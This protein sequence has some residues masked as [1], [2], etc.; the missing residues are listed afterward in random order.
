MAAQR[1]AEHGEIIF[2][3][4]RIEHLIQQGGQKITLQYFSYNVKIIIITIPQQDLITVESYTQKVNENIKKQATVSQLA[5]DD[6]NISYL[7]PA[8]VAELMFEKKAFT[9]EFYVTLLY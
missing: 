5:G 1:A 8:A 2:S 4:F 6:L 9:D 3:F 7:R